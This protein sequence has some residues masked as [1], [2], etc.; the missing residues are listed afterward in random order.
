MEI[1]IFGSVQ[2]FRLIYRVLN[3]GDAKIEAAASHCGKYKRSLRWVSVIVARSSLE[4]P[5][6]APAGRVMRE[7]WGMTLPSLGWPMRT[8]AKG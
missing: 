1:N 2:E 6:T 3:L 8:G 7:F 4:K 5:K